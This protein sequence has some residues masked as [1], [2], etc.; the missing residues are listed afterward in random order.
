MSNGE[1]QIN[2]SYIELLR[3]ILTEGRTSAKMR[4]MY[5]LTEWIE[6]RKGLRQGG[7]E[8]PSLF[9]IFIDP[10]INQVVSEFAEGPNRNDTPILAFADDILILAETQEQ[11]K[12]TLSICKRW[13]ESM[14]M[15]F[16]ESKTNL[17][18]HPAASHREVW[19]N[20]PIVDGFYNPP[21][22]ISD[23]FELE[24]EMGHLKVTE[25]LYYLGLELDSYG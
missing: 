9:N 16:N 18:Y 7:P 21:S 11:A 8:S 22:S 2:P 15:K 4:A 5:G 3:M 6:I 14:G 20:I 12:K 1:Q 25:S 24:T 10:L 19:R 13:I 17:V 23:L